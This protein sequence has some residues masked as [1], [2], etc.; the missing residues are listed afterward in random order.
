MSC[1]IITWIIYQVP[2]TVSRNPQT[3]LVPLQ[4]LGLVRPPAS[5]CTKCLQVLIPLRRMYNFV[6]D[7]LLGHCYFVRAHHGHR[8]SWKFHGLELEDHFSFISTGCK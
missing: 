8:T 2:L 3:G 1:V 5:D 7:E 4:T 6:E